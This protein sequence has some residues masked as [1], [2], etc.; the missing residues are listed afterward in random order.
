[1]QDE[2]FANGIMSN[3]SVKRFM[4]MES[5]EKHIPQGYGE[6]ALKRKA[7]KMVLEERE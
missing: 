5:Q 3:I 4:K 1:M 2:N 6:L 7:G